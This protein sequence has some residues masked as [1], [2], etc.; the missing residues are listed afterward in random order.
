PFKLP[1]YV[2]T[3]L[4]P[5]S[6]VLTPYLTQPPLQPYLHHLPFNFLPYPSTTSI[7]NSPPLLPQIQ[8][9]IPHHHLLVTSL[10]SPNRNFQGPIHPLLKP[11]YLPSPHLLL[12]YPLPPTLDI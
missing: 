7:P 3:S 2:K 5:A 6:K 4:A 9:P 12:P 8:K 10:L 11:N 1:Q